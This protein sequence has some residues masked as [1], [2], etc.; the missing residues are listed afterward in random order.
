MISARWILAPLACLTA[1]APLNISDR[2][3]TIAHTIRVRHPGWSSGEPQARTLV[4]VNDNSGFPME[5]RMTIDSVICPEQTCKMIS[6]TMIWDALGRYLR[7]ELPPGA[8]LEKGVVAEQQT[9]AAWAAAV[10]K[11]VPFTEADYRKLDAILRDRNSLLGQQ[12]LAKLA[13]A[14]GKDL[15]DG[16][17]GATPAAIR[18]AVVAGASLTCYN[19]WHWANGDVVRKAEELTRERASQAMLLDFLASGKPHYALFALEQLRVRK[20]FCP[21]VA[22]AVE[23]ALRTGDRDR[24]DAG[25]AYLKEAFPDADRFYSKVAAVINRCPSEGRAYLLD[26]MGADAALSG[27]FFE[28]LSMYLPAWDN[29]YEIHLFLQ[30][31]AR[32]NYASPTLFAQV[33]KLLDNPNFFIARRAHAFLSDQQALDS[34]TQSRLQAF[35]EKSASEGRAL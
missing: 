3:Q 17:T 34:R 1:C 33:A 2:P 20:L 16:I 32:R 7:Y 4:Q 12:E 13:G 21:A 19:L 29:Y 5:Y 22:E 23:D 28:R 8:F 26:R 6:I 25:L 24:L 18:D 14:K 27:A 11:G 35:R 10:W 15:V 31:A 30:L 9:P